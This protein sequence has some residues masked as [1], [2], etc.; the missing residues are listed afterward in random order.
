M[1]EESHSTGYADCAYLFS[2]N[3]KNK[4]VTFMLK[5]EK[6]DNF[7]F[8]PAVSIRYIYATVLLYVLQINL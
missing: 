4:K 1:L 2:R 5:F 8:F 3:E 7:L 6:F